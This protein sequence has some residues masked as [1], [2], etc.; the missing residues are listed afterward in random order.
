[1]E[2]AS[3]K[4][5][6]SSTN[7]SWSIAIGASPVFESSWLGVEALQSGAEASRSGRPRR[8]NHRDWEL[9]HHR[10]AEASWSGA[11]VLPTSESLRRMNRR[12]RVESTAAMEGEASPATW[13]VSVWGRNI[14]VSSTLRW[15]SGFEK[16]GKNEL[17]NWYIKEIYSDDLSFVAITCL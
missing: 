17:I 16:Y 11:K 5:E 15:P 7:G 2:E 9:K 3:P 14:W 8:L 12:R 13:S 10:S 4:D 1:M 6:S